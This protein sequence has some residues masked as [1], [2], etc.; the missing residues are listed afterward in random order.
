M[1]QNKEHEKQIKINKLKKL[2]DKKENFWEWYLWIL[3]EAKI[4]D[5][6]YDVKG[7][8][9]WLEH[10]YQLYSKIY[11]LV[12]EAYLQ[13]D[14]KQMQFPTLIKE[15]IFLKE[16]D[17]IRNFEDDVF[18]VD[19]EGRKQ[20]TIGERLA[21]RPTS[22]LIIYPS[23][24]RWIQSWR[25]L[26]LKVFQNVSIFRCETNETRPLIR[27]RETI[28]FIE[29]HSAFQTKEEA[30]IFLEYI[31][32]MYQELFKKIGIPIILVDVP[33]WDRFAGS[34]KTIDG[35]VLFPENKALELFTSA[36]LGTTFSKIFNIEYLNQSKEK[37]LVHL[38]CYGPSIDRILASIISLYS[39]NHGLIL[40][41][42]LA[43]YEIVI[44]PIF[45]RK[46]KS[47]IL[48]Y[49]K[50]ILDLI[51][52]LGYL[53]YLDNNESKSPGAK[54]YETEKIGIPFRIE[55]G[56]KELENNII[57]IVQRDNFN[58]TTLKSNT[59]TMKRKLHELLANYNKNLKK[60]IFNLFK[61]SITQIKSV[62]IL[63]ALIESKQLVTSK[64]YILGWCGK[65]KCAE[66][67]ESITNFSLLG[68]YHNKRNIKKNCL[69][70][71]QLG[72]EAI[73]AKR[74]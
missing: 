35:Y 49:S 37:K 61:N 22:E 72:E 43:L 9:I 33:E 54:F 71:Q 50:Q 7:C 52:R 6:D 62:D 36:Y 23:F 5:I 40:P 56:Q 47:R 67:I 16:T 69:I 51:I 64:F 45:N 15:N 2:P 73:L 53:A 32:K 13:L 30:I 68:Y 38:L 48:R 19:R 57:T 1:F 21:L 34:T 4:V 3:R 8:Y 31:W 58:R 17:F 44:I 39:D 60:R 63:N 42:N 24:A 12:K 26:P 65:R 66:K 28:G 25:D 10:G 59:I 46:N 14:H 27:N 41:S 20:L 55:I 11:S 18:W 74:Y 29:G 70:C